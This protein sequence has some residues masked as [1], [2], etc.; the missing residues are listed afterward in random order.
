MDHYVA[1]DVSLNEISVCVLGVVFEGKTAADPPGEAP[2]L[3]K[4]RTELDAQ[5]RGLPKM[6]A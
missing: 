3:V 6:F 2:H 5:L 1:I 4:I